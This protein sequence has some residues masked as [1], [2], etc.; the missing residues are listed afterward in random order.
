MG[1]LKRSFP[2]GQ[3]QTL[4]SNTTQIFFGVN[5]GGLPGGAGTAEYVSSRLGE[6]T[7]IVTSGGTSSGTSRTWSSG[8]NQSSGGGSSS[9]NGSANWNQQVRKLLQP[10][11][12]VA[13]SPRLAITFTPGVPPVLSYLQ[14]YY[15]KGFL[16]NYPG[17]LRRS[18]NACNALLTGAFLCALAVGLAVVATQR[19]ME[20]QGVSQ[21]PTW[22]FSEPSVV[23]EQQPAIGVA[24]WPSGNGSAAR[25]GVAPGSHPAPRSFPLQHEDHKTQRSSTKRP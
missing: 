23:Q 5:D 12:V 6:Q 7:V 8:G 22:Q 16:Q 25:Q 13:L 17:R 21:Q 18:A 19:E 20:M 11:E 9:Y 3:D 24:P 2:D 1:Q 4:L 15:E 14:R 10:S